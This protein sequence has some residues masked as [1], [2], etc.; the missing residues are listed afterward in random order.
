[1]AVAFDIDGGKGFPRLSVFPPMV[2]LLIELRHWWKST[3]EQVGVNPT[4]TARANSPVGPESS[5]SE[6]TRL[7]AD[8][9]SLTHENGDWDDS[10]WKVRIQNY[11]V[12]R[13][14]T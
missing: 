7:R 3:A 12:A 1:M 2:M 4:T 10:S 5:M 13:L 11:I 9:K 14:S 8:R 6:E